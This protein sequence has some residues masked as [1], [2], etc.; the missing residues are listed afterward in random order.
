VH[1]K[2]HDLLAPGLNLWKKKKKKRKVGIRRKGEEKRKI[3]KKEGDEHISSLPSN[4]NPR[5]RF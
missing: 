4:V 5:G 2:E 3:L 1:Y